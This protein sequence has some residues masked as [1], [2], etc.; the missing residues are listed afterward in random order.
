MGM[1]AELERVFD[2]IAAEIK[3]LKTQV[4]S[5]QSGGSNTGGGTPGITASNLQEKYVSRAELL[6]FAGGS[7]VNS[8]LF[9]VKFDKP[10]DTRPF[11]IVQADIVAASTRATYVQNINKFGF[12]MA[13]T[14]VADLKGVWYR[15]YTLE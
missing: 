11:V 14:Y 6:A 5:I 7:L 15:A 9:T 3:S 12:D 13:C 8:K 1:I 2:K 4:A 10:F